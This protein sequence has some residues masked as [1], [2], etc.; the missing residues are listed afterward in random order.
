MR[1]DSRSNSQVSSPWPNEPIPGVYPLSSHTTGAIDPKAVAIRDDT[2]NY[3]G[4]PWFASLP[5]RT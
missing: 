2:A 3:N 4:A 1:Q 5:T